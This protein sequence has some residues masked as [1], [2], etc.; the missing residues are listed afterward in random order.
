MRKIIK[1]ISKLHV[2]IPPWHLRQ[3][4]RALTQTMPGF[5]KRHEQT[6]VSFSTR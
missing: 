2:T 3:T 5:A 4:E 1:N 6:T